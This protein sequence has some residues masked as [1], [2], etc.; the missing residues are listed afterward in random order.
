MTLELNDYGL[1]FDTYVCYIALSWQVII[2]ATIALI[3]YKI[4]K[5]R[6]KKK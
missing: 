5:K 6:N 1:E 4:Y 3:A 2:P